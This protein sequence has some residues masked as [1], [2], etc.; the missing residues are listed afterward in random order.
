MSDSDEEGNIDTF[1]PYESDPTFT[2]Q[3]ELDEFI[4]KCDQSKVRYFYV[5]KLLIK[6]SS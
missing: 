5:G 6:T 4:D 1:D 2:T 3:E